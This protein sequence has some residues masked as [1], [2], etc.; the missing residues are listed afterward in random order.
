MNLEDIIQQTKTYYCLECGKCTS[1]CPV[2]RYDPSFSPRQMIENALLGFGDDLL[3]DRELFSCLTCYTCQ[4]KCPSDI[5][6]P[7]FVQKARS[8]AQGSG[9]HG[10]CAHSGQLQS[11]AR[12]M[13]SPAIKQKRL[14]WL[15]KEYRVSENSEVLLWVGCA[16]YFAPIFE[17]IE[18]N[19][20]D[21]TKA[22][23]KTLNVLGIEPK[24]LPNEK[25]CGHDALWTGDIETF[26]KLAEYNAAQIREAGIKKIVFSCPE[27]Y[28]TFKL[29]YPN[30]VDLDCE[31]QHISEFLA[32]KIGQ[33]GV[34]FKEIKKKV[35]YQD[36]CRLGRHL[37]VYDAPR[38]VIQSIPG[39]ELVE[40]RHSGLESICCGTSA[41]TNCDSYSNMLR[42]ERLCE[43]TETGAELLITAC[44]K[45]QTHFRCAMVDKGEEHRSTPKIE[46]MDLANLVASAIEKGR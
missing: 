1:I 22:S 24:L 11:V 39:I 34:K 26:R 17:G 19:A 20:L 12:L 28:R 2:A 27:G 18:F 45:C 25:C 46:V 42:A 43:A 36:P 23:L 37:G 8:L 14:E 41:F 29:D 4:Q 3:L 38:K 31:V 5:D 10:V 6:F 13:T 32:E 35:T 40:M 21:I 33:N 44:P 30:Y 15:S 7:L 9:Q 16:P